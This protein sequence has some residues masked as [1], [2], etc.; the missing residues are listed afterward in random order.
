MG[1]VKSGTTTATEPAEVKEEAKVETSPTE[2]IKAETKEVT[3]KQEAGAVASPTTGIWF[4]NPTMQSV[5][6]TAAY[7]DFPQVIASQGAFKEAGLTGKELGK[8]IA[9][10]PVQ[11]KNKLVCSPNSNDDEA[12]E[13]F[14]AAYEGE[15][16][17][18]GRSIEECVE[19]AKANGYEKADIKKYIDLFAYV[20]GHESGDN[21]MVDEVVVMQLSPMSVVSWR[22]FSKKLE[23]KVAF[24]QLHLE[25]EFVVK[26]V[27]KSATN[28]VGKQYTYYEFEQA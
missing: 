25:K 4:T 3:V 1:L 14:A 9:F 13:Y 5:V 8:W 26:A 24:G 20:V 15:C 28:K 6:D 11:A 27:A 16:A 18:D 2:E 7:G 22:K 12:K 10:K 19:D 23:A 21:L 17:S